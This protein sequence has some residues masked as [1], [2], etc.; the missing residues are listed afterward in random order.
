MTKKVLLP[1]SLP[2]IGFTLHKRAFFY[3]LAL[4]YGW[5]LNDVP[6]QHTCGTNFT[7]DHSHSLLTEGG[8]PSLSHNEVCNEVR[9]F[10]AEMLTE[11]CHDVKLESSLQPLSGETFQRVS[12]DT[13]DKA[14][15]NISVN[16]F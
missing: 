5:Q 4:H 14:R 9:N 11:V 7:V 16:G 6:M 10:M 2:S 13:T 3:S 8:F 12:V 15:F 1:G